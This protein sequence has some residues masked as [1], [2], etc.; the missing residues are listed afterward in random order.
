MIMFWHWL[1]LFA[2]IIPKFGFW[3]RFFFLQLFIYLFFAF[4]ISSIHLSISGILKISIDSKAIL[5]L[6]VHVFP[7]KQQ[8]LVS[9]LFY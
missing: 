3:Y 9:G 4:V 5:D 7:L 6:I 2:S 8:L 1:S